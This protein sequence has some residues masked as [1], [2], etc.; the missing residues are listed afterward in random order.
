VVFAV[1]SDPQTPRFNGWEAEANGLS[2][3]GG[4]YVRNSILI[5]DSSI[6]EVEAL[7]GNIPIRVRGIVCREPK[8]GGSEMNMQRKQRGLNTDHA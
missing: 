8:T 1:P 3:C 4:V 6:R 5:T 7:P 2:K